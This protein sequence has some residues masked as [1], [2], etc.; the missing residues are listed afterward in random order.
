[1]QA[2]TDLIGALQQPISDD[3]HGGKK[4]ALEEIINRG[5]F[6]TNE[7]REQLGQM[8]FQVTDPRVDPNL[9]NQFYS[10]TAANFEKELA[11]DPNNLRTREFAA[12]FY[13]RFGQNEKALANFQKAIE[14]SPNRQST[15]LDLSMTYI[16][17]GNYPAAEEKAK[18]AY[19]LD[20]A[21]PDAALTYA[22]ALIYNHKNDESD[23][24][25]KPLRDKKYAAA[26]DTRIVNAY[27]NM[28][29][30]DKVI[31]LVNGKIAAGY[32]SARD[33]FAIAGAYAETKQK[34]KAIGAL[35]TAEGL[36]STLKDQADS[37]IQQLKSGK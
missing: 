26:Y 30:F 23:K 33:Y 12:T 9:R 35:Q 19:D 18:I 29:E 21:N 7:A 8:A 34:D 20:S 24:V 37:L 6:G 3:G 11:E 32:A 16:S 25:I 36:D 4:I 22:T 5:L 27:G 15:Y 17:I 13:A 31:E 1:M 14:L 2:N 28:K 10:L